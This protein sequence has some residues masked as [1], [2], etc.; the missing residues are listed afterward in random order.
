M[1]GRPAV[2][3]EL[4]READKIVS[5]L[6][7]TPNGIAAEGVKSRADAWQIVD[8]ETGRVLSWSADV[9][10]RYPKDLDSGRLRLHFEGNEVWLVRLARNDDLEA[11]SLGSIGDVASLVMFGLGICVVG[12]IAI[13]P[14]VKRSLRSGVRR[15]TTLEE[16]LRTGE[17]PHIE[18]KR[19][20][21]ELQQFLKDVTGFANSFGGTVFI[22]VADSKEVV[23]T[24]IASPQE[25]DR[26]ER[27]VRD[28]VRQGI[29]PSPDIEVDFEEMNRQVVARVFVRAGWQRHSFEGR[30]YVRQGSQSVFLVNGEIDSL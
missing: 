2:D 23:G 9:P 28:S 4:T 3:E 27:R 20:V 17:D 10:A 6:G 14:I 18:F 11:I 5:R 22:G 19:E 1:S 13:H 21:R 16:A 25:K 26:F 7:R 30:Y 12:F 29:E 24:G 8:G 15:P